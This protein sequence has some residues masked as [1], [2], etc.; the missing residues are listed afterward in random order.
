MNTDIETASDMTTFSKS[1][2]AKVC[3]VMHNIDIDRINLTRTNPASN[4]QV[5]SKRLSLFEYYAIL[6]LVQIQKDSFISHVH[7]YDAIVVMKDFQF[8]AINL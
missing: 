3:N 1:C 2:Q 5:L 7:G 6:F 8:A 4:V